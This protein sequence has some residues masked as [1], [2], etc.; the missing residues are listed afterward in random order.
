MVAVVGA[1]V[2]GRGAGR[3]RFDA[4]VADRDR[5]VAPPV[6]ERLQKIL[7][8][9]GLGSRRS[10]EA[11]IAAGRISVNGRRVTELGASADPDRDVIEVD[12]RAV[13]LG[14]ARVYLALPKP[15][16]P[17]TPPPDPQGR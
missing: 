13:R 12:G 4:P 8:R 9:A 2:G 1:G 17:G 10:S 5:P 3:R 14:T 16:D 15:P 11:L 6:R 7:A